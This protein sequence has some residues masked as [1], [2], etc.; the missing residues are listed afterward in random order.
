MCK[1][2][3]TCVSMCLHVYLITFQTYTGLKRQFHLHVRLTTLNFPECNVVSYLILTMLYVA[4]KMMIWHYCPGVW[5]LLCLPRLPPSEMSLSHLLV[6]RR[7]D[8]RSETLSQSQSPR[9][10]SQHSISSRIS[11]WR[12]HTAV[13]RP[14]YGRR[15]RLQARKGWEQAD[16]GG[17]RQSLCH[18]CYTRAYNGFIARQGSAGFLS[19]LTH[20]CEGPLWA[21]C[22]KWSHVGFLVVTRYTCEGPLKRNSDPKS[23]SQKVL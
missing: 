13:T 7:C 20:T 11:G 9:P 10:P 1:H 6:S 15:A 17:H 23:I 22:H 14:G 4:L 8:P 2:V 5:P 3:S 12:L 16:P 21:A 18:V 19:L